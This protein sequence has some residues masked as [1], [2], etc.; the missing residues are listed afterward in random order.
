MVAGNKLLTFHTLNGAIPRVNI[1]PYTADRNL[2]HNWLRN[3]NP[4]IVRRTVRGS[5]GRGVSYHEWNGINTE[6]LPEAPLYTQYIKK[7]AEYRIHVFLDEVIDQQQKKKRRNFD[8]QVDTRI[9]SH[10]RGWIFARDD[11]RVPEA[12]RAQAINAVRALGLDFGAVDVIWNNRAER[13]YV[14]EINTAPGLEGRTI[15]SYG[16]AIIEAVAGA[17]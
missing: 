12:V 9:R 11:I 2:A 10:D 8:G 6:P 4:V 14:L 1:P 15:E 17:V 3:R 7:M 13:A 5:G 16:R